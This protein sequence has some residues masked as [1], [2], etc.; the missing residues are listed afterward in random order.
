[1][2]HTLKII[3]FLFISGLLGGVQILATMNNNF[4]NAGA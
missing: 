4:V 1:M 3:F 2:C